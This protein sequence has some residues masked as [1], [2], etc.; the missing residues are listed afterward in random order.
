MNTCI[1]YTIINP[2]A[3]NYISVPYLTKAKASKSDETTFKQI[4]GEKAKVVEDLQNI[5]GEGRVV[6]YSQ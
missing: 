4:I 2:Q 1:P 6:A 5:T 3:F